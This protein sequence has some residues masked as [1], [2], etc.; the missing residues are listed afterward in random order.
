MQ[1]LYQEFRKLPNAAT[2]AHRALTEHTYGLYGADRGK[3]VGPSLKAILKP[4]NDRLGFSQ[5]LKAYRAANLKKLKVFTQDSKS[6]EKGFQELNARNQ[7]AL[8]GILEQRKQLIVEGER[9]G[10]WTP[11]EAKRLVERNHTLLPLDKRLASKEPNWKK[12]TKEAFNTDP[13]EAH[14]YNIHSLYRAYELNINKLRLFEQLYRIPGKGKK[15]LK[16]DEIE[17]GAVF[18]AEGRLRGFKQVEGDHL[19]VGALDDTAPLNLYKD[20]KYAR[21]AMPKEVVRAVDSLTPAEHNWLVNNAGMVSKGTRLGTIITPFFWAKMVTAD[22]ALAP[23]FSKNQFKPVWGHLSGSAHLLFSKM[24]RTK[25][26]LFKKLKRFDDIYQEAVTEGAFGASYVT[27]DMSHTQLRTLYGH[28]YQNIVNLFKRSDMESLAKALH[29]ENTM[30]YLMRN[31]KYGAHRTGQALGRAT[32]VLDRVARLEEYRL[33]RQQGK[34]ARAAAFDAREINMDFTR[35]GAQMKALD[36][37][38]A[39]LNPA[40]QSGAK[41]A[42][43][44]KNQ[45]T[46]LAVRGLMGI[47]LP[48][49]YMEMV[50]QD[51]IHN[52]PNSIEAK[53]LE[54][55][56]EIE[57]DFY[58]NFVNVDGTIF[59]L[60]LPFELGINFGLPAKYLARYLYKTADQQER[61]NLLQYM[62]DEG[63]FGEMAKAFVMPYEPN[64]ITLFREPQDNYNLFQDRPMIAGYQM[65]YAPQMRSGK[66]TS[67]IAKQMSLFLNGFDVF[68][69]TPWLQRYTTPT[70]IDHLLTAW[71]GQGGRQV[72]FLADRL[73]EQFGIVDPA[74]RD[75]GN[76]QNI[77]GVSTFVARTPTQ[78]AAPLVKAR[79]WLQKHDILFNSITELHER[80]NAYGELQKQLMKLPEDVTQSEMREME[81]HLIKTS[82]SLRDLGKFSKAIRLLTNRTKWNA[83][84][85]ASL[86]NG[87]QVVHEMDRVQ[88]AINKSKGEF[89]PELKEALIDELTWQQI[90]VARQILKFKEQYEQKIY[91]IKKP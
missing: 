58:L 26:E 19:A 75:W 66:A 9:A 35:A 83:Q 36:K 64:A 2:R 70:A 46:Q 67:Q 79:D 25:P 87:I 12:L 40:L 22:L 85:L 29:P 52:S 88:N 61:Q 14:I 73:A 48:A 7:G 84:D 72:L 32:D 65:R 54:A 41:I 30:K 43:Y 8:N 55:L 63:V 69:E 76:L 37:A 24:Y 13:A 11:E 10:Y 38:I 6:I 56:T 51:I 21:I 71:N 34:S 86:M 60:R 18:D 5:Y 42:N 45:P 50:R 68:S 33:A 20:G 80:N 4:I 31:F 3:I 89:S 53:N 59:K 82:G 17:F 77:P 90:G 57:Q 44:A 49:F 91:K 15:A 39:F 78:A 62:W 27:Q 74:Y 23:I 81:K 47:T 16:A 1:M 28:R